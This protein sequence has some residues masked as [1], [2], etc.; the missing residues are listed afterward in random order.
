MCWWSSIKW[1]DKIVKMQQKSRDSNHINIQFSERFRTNIFVFFCQ[2]TEHIQLAHNSA[3]VSNRQSFI[4]TKW[5]TCLFHLLFSQVPFSK[6]RWNFCTQKTKTQKSL[7][8][9]LSLRKT[10]I[11]AQVRP[12][13]SWF[14]PPRDSHGLNVSI[15]QYL[16]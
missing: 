6:C 10:S 4:N 16:R 13:S 9:R 7:W 14:G 5:D 3:H 1:K 15:C 11:G 8:Y 2:F 12:A